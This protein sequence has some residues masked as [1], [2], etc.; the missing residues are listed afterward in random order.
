MRVPPLV[1]PAGLETM[2]VPGAAGIMNAIVLVAVLSGL[3]PG[4]YMPIP[5]Y[6]VNEPTPG[7]ASAISPSLRIT[8]STTMLATSTTDTPPARPCRASR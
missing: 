2:H 1:S 7:A 3:N 6:S 4:L 5:A 8:S